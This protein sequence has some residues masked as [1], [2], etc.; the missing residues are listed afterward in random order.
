M[1]FKA[2]ISYKH[3]SS[4]RFAER[5]ELALK[6]YAKPLYRP[7]M[8]IF[9]D[10]KHLRAGGDL[11][12]LI[13][14]A[15]AASEFLVFLAS[16]EAAA[17][18]WVR[19]ELSYWCMDAER[20]DRLIIV[21]T[22]GTIATDPE[23][24]RIDWARTDAL[25][26]T[27]AG[28]LVSV[29]LYLDLSWAQRDEQQ[30]ILNPEYKKAVNLIVATLRHVDPIELSG[31]EVLQHR[32][33]LR[34]RRVLLGSLAALA[35]M[36]AATTWF[37]WTQQR[38]A[39]LRAR[40]A[41]SRRLAAEADRLAD[42]RIDRAL[43]LMAQAYRMADN[44]A[45]RASWWRL[46]GRV[47]L[48]QVYLPVRGSDV[49][50]EEDG[51]LTV[52]T[53]GGAVS[54]ATGTDGVWTRVP[55]SRT[56]DAD[57]PAEWEWAGGCERQ[58]CEEDDVWQCAHDE[59]RII[60]PYGDSD[61]FCVRSALRV[62]SWCGDVTLDVPGYDVRARRAGR[63]VHVTSNAGSAS[64]LCARESGASP[65]RPLLVSGDRVFFA[66]DGFA[67]VFESGGPPVTRVS[68]G[69]VDGRVAVRRS[70]G[71]VEIWA[72]QSAGAMPPRPGTTPLSPDRLVRAIAA[73]PAGAIALAL[74]R[75]GES[76]GDVV[77]WR[78]VDDALQ[79]SA[80]HRQFDRLWQQ[81]PAAAPA[82]V[83]LERH[84][85]NPGYGVLALSND[86][87][88]LVTGADV[89]LSIVDTDTGQR[90][91][92]PPYLG[93]RGAL[94]ARFSDSNVLALVARPLDGAINS[95]G[96]L[97]GEGLAS[98]ELGERVRAMAFLPGDPEGVLTAGGR[99]VHAWS[100]KTGG[101]LRTITDAPADGVAIDPGTGRL[102]ISLSAGSDT[103]PA[104]H[105]ELRSPHGGQPITSGRQSG[106]TLAV[107]L[108]SSESVVLWASS[109][110]LQT[111]AW[112]TDSWTSL[113]TVPHLDVR[114]LG[115]G[116]V[117]AL[118]LTQA[119]VY[120]LR[121]ARWL[122]LTCA[123]VRRNLTPQEWAAHIGESFPYEETCGR[124]ASR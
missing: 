17:S 38:E 91:P 1:K 103:L 51:S 105:L 55:D 49:R 80:P 119:V 20:R 94:F 31:E 70:D 22:D 19:D 81:R 7:P 100:V 122:E 44:A 32:R 90:L 123:I 68:L 37:A 9:R 83:L 107:S 59:S 106:R 16:P 33:N 30:T 71:T 79:G 82:D 95:G 8:A 21:L 111:W 24:K 43:L 58:E 12:G 67:D 41:T 34:V 98:R 36:L 27:L 53:G 14:A 25:P 88:R 35:M 18:T 73:S 74:D 23:T 3:V 61:S 39:D 99:G 77:L 54:F 93:R 96:Q 117:L 11:P 15:L 6:A 45:L 65:A 2:F 124:T 114:S 4:T 115:N 102:A 63:W 72:Q 50:F 40:E 116:L 42:E 48:P 66:A 108:A 101:L 78:S 86:G 92:D 69:H 60:G 109:T 110:G 121:P 57:G 84:G 97:F 62:P 87:T 5:L 64:F 26:P 10:E 85:V 52:T 112:E 13:R 113:D 104:T 89:E 29:P 56:H 75:P 76:G 118:R 120:D 47:D 46:L 28:T